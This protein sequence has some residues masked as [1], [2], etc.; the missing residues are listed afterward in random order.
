[1]KWSE[2]QAIQCETVTKDL[3][4]VLGQV[5]KISN[6]VGEYDFKIDFHKLLIEVTWINSETQNYFFKSSTHSS[7]HITNRKRMKFLVHI[8]PC[9]IN[10]I[11]FIHESYTDFL[12]K[13]R[14]NADIIAKNKQVIVMWFACVFRVSAPPHTIHKA[15]PQRRL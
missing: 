13:E 14:C 8:I 7:K 3:L 12:T 11:L 15:C 2:R 9:A 4:S 5:E 6:R 10:H 1:M